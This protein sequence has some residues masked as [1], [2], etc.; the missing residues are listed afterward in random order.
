MGLK[1]D[2]RRRGYTLKKG[3]FLYKKD[4]IVERRAWGNGMQRRCMAKDVEV[5]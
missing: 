2:V 5:L 4:I 3:L 1:G